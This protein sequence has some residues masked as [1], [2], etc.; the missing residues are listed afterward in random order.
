MKRP[1]YLQHIAPPAAARRRTDAPLLVPSPLLFRPSAS[2]PRFIET[3]TVAPQPVT[4][5]TPASRSA[6]DATGAARRIRSGN[7]LYSAPTRGT[8]AAT[9][10]IMPP[11]VDTPSRVAPHESVTP[12]R[13]RRGADERASLPVP[14]RGAELATPRIQPLGASTPRGPPAARRA[15]PSAAPAVMPTGAPSRD[16]QSAATFTAP[17]SAPSQRAEPPPPIASP[18]GRKELRYPE[19]LSD[20]RTNLMQAAPAPVPMLAPAPG[21]PAPASTLPRAPRG[22]ANSLAG[23]QRTLHIGTLEVRVIGSPPPTAPAPP[24]PGRAAR[25]SAAPRTAIGR[26]FGVFG[27]GQS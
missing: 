19:D 2:E 13:D 5:G 7:A 8:E 3:D 25:R 21:A 1:S 20:R 26:G 17:R 4:R 15:N 18:T 22:T 9:P 6:A 14:A 16:S 10:T 11:G 24:G 23:A 27:L 12:P